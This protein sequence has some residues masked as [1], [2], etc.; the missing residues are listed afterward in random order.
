MAP[1]AAST[2]KSAGKLAPK[3]TAATF[4]AISRKCARS[5]RRHSHR[6]SPD[7]GR[8]QVGAEV[9]HYLGRDLA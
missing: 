7:A 5:T 9:R 2:K 3:I 4:A 6:M 1:T 8:L